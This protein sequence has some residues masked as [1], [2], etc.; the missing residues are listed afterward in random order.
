MGQH[1][2]GGLALS[3]VGLV[4]GSAFGGVPETGIPDS[5]LSKTGHFLGRDDEP[6]QGQRKAPDRLPDHS[7]HGVLPLGP[8]SRIEDLDSRYAG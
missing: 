6:R 8:T 4:L 7:L 1:S 5:A 2:W 3:G